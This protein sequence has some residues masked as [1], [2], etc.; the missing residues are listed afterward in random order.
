MI[1]S[2]T[3]VEVKGLSKK[4]CRRLKR[5]LWYGIRDI[6]AELTGSKRN[7]A[8]LRKEEFWALKDVSFEIKQGEL[9]GLIGANGAGKTTLLRLLSGLIKPDEGEITVRGK[10]QALIALGAGFNPVLTARENIYINGAVLGFSK[11]EMDQLL[12]EIMEFA[13]IREFID[14]PV[15]SY[16]SGMQ[17]RLGFSVAV[18]LKPDIL[19]V[20]EVLAVGDASFRRKAR[21]KMMELLHSGISVLFVS[22]NMALVSSLT[23]R[24]I[25]LDKGRVISVGTSDKVTSLYLSDS[26]RRS[27]ESQNQE[28]QEDYLMASAY[29]TVPEV[30]VLKRF[31]IR[32]DSDVETNEFN[33]YDNIKIAFEI[34]FLEKTRDVTLAFNIRDQVDDVIISSSKMLLNSRPCEGI[35]GGECEIKKNKLREGNYNIGFYAMDHENGALYKSH[36]V[37]SFTILADMDIIEKGDS[38]QGFMVMDTNWKVLE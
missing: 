1:K 19:I 7:R 8:K 3:L 23:S 13:E 29:V 26:I 5:S 21:N 28:E 32:S 9:V 14:M 6:G 34:Q 11:K 25:Y 2:E 10:I 18:N 12:E 24:C 20:D 22:H 4:F 37:G 36:Q 35:I 16:S 17:V 33:T 31:Y 27:K 38:T 15:Q 30:F